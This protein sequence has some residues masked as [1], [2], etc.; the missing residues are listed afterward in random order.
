MSQSD[1]QAMRSC[2]LIS[3]CNGPQDKRILD[4][5]K[6]RCSSRIALQECFQSRMWRDLHVS[7]HTST[8]QVV[9]EAYGAGGTGFIM[10]CLTDN[11]NRSA[12][13]EQSRNV[14]IL[15]KEGFLTKACCLCSLPGL[16]GAGSCMICGMLSMQAMLMPVS[17]SCCRCKDSGDKG[18]RKDG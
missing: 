2:S 18:R 8:M 14:Y 13:G 15:K 6:S 11:V 3:N 7:Q 9:Y 4:A 17:A 12:T 5:H 10:E 16:Q 1:F